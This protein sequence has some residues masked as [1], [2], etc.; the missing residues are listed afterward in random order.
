MGGRGSPWFRRCHT[1]S[2][3]DVEVS[4]SDK[5][6]YCATRETSTGDTLTMN[7]CSRGE[8]DEFCTVR[9]EHCMIQQIVHMYSAVDHNKG[10]KYST[11]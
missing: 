10:K 9:F 3:Y 5:S 11:I 6:A 7:E 8:K 4:A 2:F 1:C